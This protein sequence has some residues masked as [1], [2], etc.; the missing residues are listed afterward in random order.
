M[1]D[2]SLFWKIQIQIVT[3]AIL[4][5][6][7]GYTYKNFIDGNGEDSRPP[8]VPDMD[9]TD[10]FEKLELTESDAEVLKST[11]TAAA[12][13]CVTDGFRRQVNTVSEFA[14]F[15]ESF[16]DTSSEW[17]EKDYS[18][19]SKVIYGA[20]EDESE[21]WI[22]FPQSGSLDD[23]DYAKAAAIFEALARSL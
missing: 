12:A 11:F 20:F 2:L 17:L 14:S 1:N 8:Y 7:G 5:V 23:E 18:G 10:D 21:T 9:F 6:A 19:L 3:I 16:G 22:R 13:L 4:L 15:L